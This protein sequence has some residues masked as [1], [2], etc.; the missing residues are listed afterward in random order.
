MKAVTSAFDEND[1]SQEKLSAQME[2]LNRQIDVQVQRVKLLEQGVQDSAKQF[3][4]GSRETNRWQEALNNAKADLSVMQRN[5]SQVKNGLEAFSEESQQAAQK[6][7]KNRQQNSMVKA[8][9]KRTN[10]RVL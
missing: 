4:E 10:G 5:L 2:V 1:Q 7:Q 3:G 8:A 9:K 6:T